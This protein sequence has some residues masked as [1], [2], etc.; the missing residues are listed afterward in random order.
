[1]HERQ[2]LLAAAPAAAPGDEQASSVAAA[3]A[4]APWAPLRTAPPV[5]SPTAAARAAE[6]AAAGETAGTAAAGWAEEEAVWA[7]AG[8]QVG[9]QVQRLMSP[10]SRVLLALQGE[11]SGETQVDEGM[12]G[13]GGNGR[14]G[15]RAGGEGRRDIECVRGGGTEVGDEEAGEGA[16]GWVERVEAL[17]VVRARGRAVRKK[18]WREKRRAEQAIAWQQREQQR[19]VV[20]ARID[21]WRARVM[22]RDAQ[23]S[24]ARQQQAEEEAREKRE[25]AQLQKQ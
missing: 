15:E 11:E 1:L 19:R 13:A 12:R 14:E 6:A 16:V 3:A 10:L 24:M 17:R 5:P 25:R 8:E 2:C 23:A 18:R 4:A 22:E 20:E 9:G 7:R 21:A